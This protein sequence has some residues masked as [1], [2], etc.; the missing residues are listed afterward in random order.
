MVWEYD[1]DRFDGGTIER[2]AS[3]FATIL[4]DSI[5]DPDRHVYLAPL[6]SKDGRSGSD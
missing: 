1:R 2:L 4:S 3:H 6:M 5:G